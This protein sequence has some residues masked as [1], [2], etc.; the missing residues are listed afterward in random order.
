MV[1]RKM[2]GATM[3]PAAKRLR[4]VASTV[5][6]VVARLAATAAEAGGQRVLALTML[7]GVF[8]LLIRRQ[9]GVPSVVAVQKV[10]V[11]AIASVAERLRFDAN[12]VVFLMAGHEA[13]TARVGRATTL[14]GKMT[15]A[16]AILAR[17]A[18]SELRG[19]LKRR[20]QN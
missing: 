2:T 19:H 18:Q 9:R 13:T 8:P 7:L 11:V 6:D 20:R 14:D 1:G 3:T 4:G 17:L 10:T 15:A 5:G 12:I 16:S